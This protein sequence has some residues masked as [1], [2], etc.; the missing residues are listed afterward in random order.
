MKLIKNMKNWLI[1]CMS[2]FILSTIGC[3]DEN[4]NPVVEHSGFVLKNFSNT[5]CK[6]NYRT[7]GEENAECFILTATEKGGL[8][9]EHENVFFNCASSKF[10]ARVSI[11]GRSIT[12]KELDM[13]NAEELTSCICTY[14]LSYEIGPLEDGVV[15]SMTV[16]TTSDLGIDDPNITPV[17]EETTFN[18]VYSSVLSEV[19]LCKRSSI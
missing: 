18:F 8:Y 4:N 16:I 14:D 12:V 7:R 19:I 15:Y 5:G 3:T 10:D 17:S 9:I 6:Q 13:T 2:L 1:L 11:I